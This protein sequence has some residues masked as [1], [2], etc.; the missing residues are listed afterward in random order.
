VRSRLQD[1]G[2]LAAKPSLRNQ[3]GL[4]VARNRHKRH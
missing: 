3:V 1:L 2:L 4:E